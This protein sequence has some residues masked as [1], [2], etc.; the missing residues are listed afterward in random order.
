MG[1]G[2]R[3][4]INL[5]PVPNAMHA[6][7]IVDEDQLYKLQKWNVMVRS[8]TYVVRSRMGQATTYITPSCPVPRGRFRWPAA[9][10]GCKDPK[11]RF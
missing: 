10:L 9:G 5:L 6:S 2:G 8:L 4:F 1:M 3:G 7:S 11:P